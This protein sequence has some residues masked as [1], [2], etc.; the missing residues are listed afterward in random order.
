[1]KNDNHDEENDEEYFKPKDE[2]KEF[3][4]SDYKVY[5]AT[6]GF[7]SLFAF[8]VIRGIFWRDRIL[9]NNILTFFVFILWYLPIMFW[10]LREYKYS[11]LDLKEIRIG[12]IYFALMFHSLFVWVTSFIA[13]LMFVFKM[14]T[15]WFE[16]VIVWVSL[17]L[18]VPSYIIL[19]IF[20]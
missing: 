4:Y 9:M 10:R 2:E 1:M 16:P 7:L 6:Y 15:L 5:A 11:F 18:F 17:I 20:H 8:I 13:F 19:I 12:K 14:T 3:N